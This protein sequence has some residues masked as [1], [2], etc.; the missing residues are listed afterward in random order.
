MSS[1]L[2]PLRE[3]LL[4]V[5]KSDARK[6]KGTYGSAHEPQNSTGRSHHHL[7]SGAGGG[8]LGRLVADLPPGDRSKPSRWKIPRDWSIL[9]LVGIIS[10]TPHAKHMESCTG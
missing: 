2:R 6:C 10:I 9:Y 8:G 4:R 1:N 5:R 3:M 7:F